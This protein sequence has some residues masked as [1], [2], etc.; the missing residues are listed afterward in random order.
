MCFTER[1]TAASRACRYRA[2][3]SVSKLHCLSG[4]KE[5]DTALRASLPASKRQTGGSELAAQVLSLLL[6]PSSSIAPSF[7]R[8][9]A[10][11]SCFLLPC[12]AASSLSSLMAGDGL[13]GK[14]TW[15]PT[16]T[17]GTLTHA[18][19]RKED[20]R[21]TNFLTTSLNIHTLLLSESYIYIW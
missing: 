2:S 8:P 19:F 4:R 18:H 5:A 7:L 9:S 6:A 3:S 14:V 16:A 10:L 1:L 12:S 21:A 11:H 13:T 17:L 15:K 20:L